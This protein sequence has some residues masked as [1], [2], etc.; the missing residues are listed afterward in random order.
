MSTQRLIH[1]TAG[2]TTAAGASLTLTLTLDAGETS[3]SLNIQR[4]EM[5]P[6]KELHTTVLSV[7]TPIDTGAFLAKAM[8]TIAYELDRLHRQGYWLR[9]RSVG[10]RGIWHNELCGAR[11]HPVQSWPT[12]PSVRAMSSSR[13]RQLSLN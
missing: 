6:H 8:T 12:V 2:L 13:S 1:A 11:G 4:L 10:L 3:T 7:K 9:E 5:L